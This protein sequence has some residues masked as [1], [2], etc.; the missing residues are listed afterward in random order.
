MDK[1]WC[2][3]HRVSHGLAHRE[4][5]GKASQGILAW[6][7]LLLRVHRPMMRVNTPIPCASGYAIRQISGW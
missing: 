3:L 1:V 4:S 7:Q 6:C 2:F 5:V